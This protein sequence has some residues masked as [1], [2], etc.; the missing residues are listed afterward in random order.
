MAKKV[1]SRRKSELQVRERTRGRARVLACRCRDVLCRANYL[2]GEFLV[3]RTLY[4]AQAA[5]TVAGRAKIANE[6]ETSH[7]QIAIHDRVPSERGSAGLKE[8]GTYLM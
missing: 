2:V 5:A 6:L 1:S 3:Y 8:R 4:T 7:A